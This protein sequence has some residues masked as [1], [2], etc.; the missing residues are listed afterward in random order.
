MI[1]HRSNV[2]ISQL[3]SRD[4]LDRGLNG[5][6]LE[7]DGSTVA[8]NGRVILAVG[9]PSPEKAAIPSEA[10]EHTTP[11]TNGLVLPVDLAEK[12]LKSMPSR[13]KRAALQYTALSK[14]KNPN[15]IGLT[16]IDERGNTTTHTAHPNPD[17]YPDWKTTIQEIQGGSNEKSL[18]VCVN[19]KDLLDILKTLE[20][21]APNKGDSPL[22]LEIPEEGQG[23]I[24]RCKHVETG[25][26]LV[27]A[28]RPMDTG[29]K[30]L[31]NDKWENGVF[32]RKRAVTRIK[33]KKRS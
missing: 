24:A 26:H 16:V 17:P 25:Q 12:T 11:G 13:T 32:A 15:Q 20:S 2:E 30:W 28:L 14:V 18:K 29:G 8:S 19:R 5:L 1:I 31:P 21:A 10:C 9:P 27:A 4:P 6:R 23:I 3:A 33:T 22:F 7:A